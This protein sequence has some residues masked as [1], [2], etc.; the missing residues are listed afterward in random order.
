MAINEKQRRFCEEYLIDLNAT[1]AAIRAG[2]SEKTAAQIGC[3]N[4]IKPDIIDYL[5]IRRSEISEKTEI[6]QEWVMKRLKDISDRC[7]T[8]EPV[9]EFDNNTKS[10]KETGEYKFDSS[11][12]NKATEL[13]GK[14][15]GM[16][17]TRI[18]ATTKGE[19]LNNEKRPVMTLPDGTTLE[20]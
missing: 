5:N 20:L 1:K 18:D 16:F 12:A 7:M 11:G 9:M 10:M 13:I 3:E 17:I 15:L 19:S 2:Y 14:H 8:V 4:L 6:S